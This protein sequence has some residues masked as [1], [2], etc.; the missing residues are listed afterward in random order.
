MAYIGV[1]TGSQIEDTGV[2]R[3]VAPTPV[4]LSDFLTAFGD[5]TFP[6]T[7]VKTT[8]QYHKLFAEDE[9]TL[10]A[11]SSVAISELGLF[12]NGDPSSLRAA[13]PRVVTFTA[14]NDQRPN[15]YKTFE[16][17]MK[18]DALELEVFWQIRF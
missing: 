4:N 5:P 16:P 8:V 1:G 17:I 7:P 13:S 15:A 18:T 11:N 6:L 10:S 14:A 12:T 2:L 9:I 3:L